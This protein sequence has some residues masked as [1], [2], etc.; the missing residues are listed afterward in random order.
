M[1]A[2]FNNFNETHVHVCPSLIYGKAYS[3]KSILK[4]TS[5]SFYESFP[6]IRTTKQMYEVGFDSIFGTQ[7]LPLNSARKWSRYFQIFR[8]KNAHGRFRFFTKCIFWKFKVI[9]ASGWIS[10][11]QFDSIWTCERKNVLKTSLS[12]VHHQFN[13]IKH[14]WF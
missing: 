9:S 6:K 13:G 14:I 3:L 4:S 1:F 2:V 11:S 8:D 7:N 12:R 10:S 5:Q